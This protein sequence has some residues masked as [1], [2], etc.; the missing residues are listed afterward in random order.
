MPG[1]VWLKKGS[2]LVPNRYNVPV[3]YSVS[4]VVEISN[5]SRGA[6]MKGGEAD[7][8]V[9]RRNGRRTRSPLQRAVHTRRVAGLRLRRVGRR[10]GSTRQVRRR[11]SAPHVFRGTRGE[12]G[13]WRA[14]DANRAVWLDMAS[15]R[16]T[17]GRGGAYASRRTRRAHATRVEGPW[18]GLGKSVDAGRGSGVGRGEQIR[19]NFA[20]EIPAGI[21][22]VPG[23]TNMRRFWS[24]GVHALI[25]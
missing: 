13:G 10:D 7:P 19:A 15:R 22:N 23:E 14:N 4:P 6:C 1:S 3:P 2:Q 21:G 20:G 5:V 17:R 11:A 24:A 16:L 8:T 25:G 18:D 12:K 9:Q